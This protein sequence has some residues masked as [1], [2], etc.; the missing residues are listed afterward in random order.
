[1]KVAFGLP[2]VLLICS[3]VLIAV[4]SLCLYLALGGSRDNPAHQ[5]VQVWLLQDE[6]VQ[7]PQQA[8]QIPAKHWQL[9]A[10][11]TRQLGY[12]LGTLW[13]RLVFEPR[14][15]YVLAL[16]APFLD[17]VD[18]YLL[19]PDDQSLQQMQTGDQRP[20]AQRRL[21]ASSMMFPVQASWQSAQA[22]VYVRMRNVGLSYLPIRYVEQDAALKQATRQQMLHSFFLGILLFAALLAVL[23]ATVTRQHSLHLFSGLLLCIAAVQ[24]EL[25]GLPFQ[26]L[27]PGS[28]G[29]NRLTEWCLPLAVLSC[30]GFVS[31]YFNLSTGW[32]R[33]LFRLLMF[34]SVVLLCATQ[35]SVLLESY[36]WQSQLKQLAVFLMQACVL[37]TLSTGLWMLKSQRRKAVLF[38]LP[39]SVLMLSVVLA[40]LRALG[41]LPESAFARSVLELGTTLAAVLMTSSLVLGI[42]LEKAWQAQV[43]QALLERN[44]QL[45]K[46]QQQ[47]LN[48]SKIAPFYGLGSRLALVELLNYEL[49]QHRSRYRL[50]LLE[51][52]Q[53]SRIEAVLGR[54]QST[55]IV[56]A[57]VDSLL[58]L[59]Q[60]HGTAVVSL[61][62]ERHQ[63]LFSLATDRFALLVQHSDFVPVLTGIRKLLHQKFTVDGF[64]P[65][66]KPH[67][68]SV[69]VSSEYGQDAEELIAHA[70]LAITYVQKTA[71]HLSYQH[72]L[73]ADSRQ[74]L[75]MVAGLAHAANAG[76]FSLLF[77][78]LLQ[79]STQQPC[80]VEAFISWQHP[81]LGPVSPA[82]FIPLAEEAGLMSSI[83]A[84]VYKE[85]RKI[86][87]QLLEQ[88]I[89]LPISMNLSAQDL[90]N[91]ALINSILQ[92][93]QKYA[94]AQRVKF[95]LAESALAPDAP[96]V[97]KSLQLLKQAGSTLVMDDFGAGQSMLTKLGNLPVSELKIDMALLTMLD[98]HR[99]QLL[100]G[101][102]KLG[103]ALDM[104]VICEGVEH[105]HQLD[106]LILNGIDAVQGY[107]IARPMPAA[108]LPRWLAKH[109]TPATTSALS[110]P[111]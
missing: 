91:P 45:S 102:I 64:T 96:A 77:Q 52:Q 35:I 87:N 38:L 37:A 33:Q 12:G 86:Q 23:L 4:V 30:A 48:R 72:Q 14:D 60:R 34:L 80:G 79:I 93:E 66:L 99:E 50:L 55:A 51:F 65:D 57:Y 89:M 101:A 76:Q 106:F 18:F 3:A 40:A 105:Q 42:Y 47:E 8:R 58:V 10:D 26:W 108:E 70:A 16:D 63:T 83:T 90:E 39:M 1:M 59:C 22:E 74:R 53:Y 56:N 111:A 27:W 62:A 44:E 100:V 21:P 82:V 107:L 9:L 36:H 71:G 17:E 41:I 28:P 67:Y 109:Q 19:T 97:Q 29:W 88:Q 85:V 92:H 5:P 69:T 61:G 110:Q 7:S 20:F 31:S 73:G 6:A 95:E 103:K 68:A 81:Q 78:P 54:R 43:Q 46:L 75:A 11:P 15:G 13:F 98:T 104:T 94:S 84:W 2:K 24:A 32:L 25:N 49:Q